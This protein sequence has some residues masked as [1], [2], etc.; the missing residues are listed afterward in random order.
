MRE[1]EL[2]REFFQREQAD[3]LLEDKAQASVILGIGDDCALLQIPANQQLAT[4]VDTLVADVHFPADAK[5]EDIAERALRTNLSDLAAMGA[6]PL[7]FT[8]ALT[9]P[10]SS[11]YVSEEWLR[12]FSRGLFRAANKYEIVL[13]G[14][15]TT[16]GPLSI[17]IQVMGAVESHHAMRRDGAS[18]GDF[19]C[20]T[21][22]LGDGAA[23][24][25]VMQNRLALNADHEHYLRERFYRPTPRLIES[26]L[27]KGIASAALDISDGLVADLNHICEASDLGA[28]IDVENLPLSPALLAVGDLQQARTWALSGGDDY[29]LCF[30][31]SPEKMPELAMLIAQEK[32]NATVVGEI[33]AGVG[34]QCELEGEAYELTAQGYQHF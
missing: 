20:V 28:V 19:V 31:V 15:D 32:I 2:I 17:T 23:A 25:A 29:E 24:L 26:G 6:E 14:G 7:W 9:L 10:K 4:S 33:V 16:S 5:P 30:T 11:N 34:V 18:I 13:V 12:G 3:L 22:S 27:L 21:N 8:L 1:F